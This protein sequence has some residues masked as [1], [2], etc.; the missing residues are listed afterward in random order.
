[1]NYDELLKNSKGT[2]LTR[3]NVIE[4][5]TLLMGDDELMSL[6]DIWNMNIR[7]L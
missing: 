6:L 1:M 4:N 3:K 7:Q 5:N 2:F